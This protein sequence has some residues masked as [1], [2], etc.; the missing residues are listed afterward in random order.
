MIAA[1]LIESTRLAFVST[2]VGAFL[3][4]AWAFTP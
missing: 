3:F 2:C 4:S 1:Y